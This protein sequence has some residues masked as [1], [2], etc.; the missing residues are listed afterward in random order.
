[1]VERLLTLRHLEV[2]RVDASRLKRSDIG[3][4]SSLGGD[5]HWQTEKETTTNPTL[6]YHFEHYITIAPP[7]KEMESWNGMTLAWKGRRNHAP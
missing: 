6:M 7:D 4:S 2:S 1:M 3:T 5:R